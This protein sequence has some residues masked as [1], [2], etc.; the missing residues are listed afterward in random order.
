[1]Q[2][3]DTVLKII[4]RKT[5][6]S[7]AYTVQLQNEGYIGVG[8]EPPACNEGDVIT[9]SY[10]LNDRGYK[11]M[12]KGSLKVVSSGPAPEQAK[13]QRAPTGAGEG[14]S[15]SGY[16]EGKEVRD[17]ATQRAIQYQ[18]SRNA[19]LE[20]AK[21]ALENDCLSL[22]AKK[23]DKLDILLAFID[24]IT[25]RFNRDVSDVTKNGERSGKYDGDEQDDGAQE[26]GEFE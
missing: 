24:E 4:S 5:P 23:A 7:V 14:A 15:K 19:A 18:A 20:V 11:Q 22:G 1:M 25:D 21:M 17:I 10:D 26:V 16:W 9:L 2:L 8:F 3:Q 13:P 6:R 12:V